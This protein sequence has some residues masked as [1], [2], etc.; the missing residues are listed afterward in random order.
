MSAEVKSSETANKGLSKI[1]N[2]TIISLMSRFRK[3][4]CP[5]SDPCGVGA[6]KYLER[7]CILNI[8]DETSGAAGSIIQ[9]KKEL[10]EE[11]KKDQLARKL[12]LRPTT[13]DLKAKNILKSQGSEEELD[14]EPSIEE[15]A[16]QLKSILKKRPKEKELVESNILKG[17]KGLYN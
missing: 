7:C 14:D 8:E 17:I 9:Q 2:G 6:K 3:K 15:R 4:I 10:E 5:T 16:T 12:S 13:T 11:K 1:V